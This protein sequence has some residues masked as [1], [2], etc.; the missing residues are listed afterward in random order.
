MAETCVSRPHFEELRQVSE[1]VHVAVGIFSQ[2]KVPLSQTSR[3]T[4][5]SAARLFGLPLMNPILG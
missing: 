3:D 4:P 2:Q 5:E 1:K